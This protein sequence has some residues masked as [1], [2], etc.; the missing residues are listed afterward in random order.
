MTPS[1][2]SFNLLDTLGA[3]GFIGFAAIMYVSTSEMWYKSDIHL[4][5]RLYSWTCC[6]VMYYWVHYYVLG[7][8]TYITRSVCNPHFCPYYR[9]AYRLT[10]FPGHVRFS[11]SGKH[12]DHST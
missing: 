4:S 2:Q 3:I 1:E 7:D 11:F 6:Q 9:E 10:Y 12:G 5:Y 8:H